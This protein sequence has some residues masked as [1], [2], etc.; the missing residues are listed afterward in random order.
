MIGECHSCKFCEIIN[1]RRICGYDKGVYYTEDV[2]ADDYCNGYRFAKSTSVKKTKFFEKFGSDI[3]YEWLKLNKIGK[4]K[5]FKKPNPK[6]VIDWKE[7]LG[8]K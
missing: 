3:Y 6:I 2:S 1:N 5:K 7:F 4:E 8:W